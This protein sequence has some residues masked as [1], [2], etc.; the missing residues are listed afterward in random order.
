M[1]L[2]Y[3]RYSSYSNDEECGEEALLRARPHPCKHATP[4][5]A[6]VIFE[7][8]RQRVSSFARAGKSETANEEMH[9]FNEIDI[10]S[11]SVIHIRPRQI[12]LLVDFPSKLR[13]QPY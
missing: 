11:L 1:L 9:G 2:D 4:K 10:V 8:R 7:S 12:I 3:Y 6:I 5:R 13:R